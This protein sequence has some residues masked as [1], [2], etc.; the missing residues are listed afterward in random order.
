MSSIT[1][2]HYRKR[3][4]LIFSDANGHAYLIDVKGNLLA[5]TEPQ[6]FSNSNS[7]QAVEYGEE[8]KIVTTDSSGNVLNIKLNGEVET[9]AYNVLSEDH[10]FRAKDLDADNL[11]EYIYIDNSELL[12]YTSDMI[13]ISL[14]KNDSKFDPWLEFIEFE[15][16]DV[17]IAC[18]STLGSEIYVFDLDGSNYNGFPIQ[19]S[20]GLDISL[21][22]DQSESVLTTGYGRFL[23]V[24]SFN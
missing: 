6:N 24:Y 22:V 8:L 18:S 4:H 9:I 2:F 3:N 16:G 23:K 7:F 14:N 10:Y 19:G 5:K 17:K 15:A 13:L 1:H 20:Y 11:P 21:S 12:V